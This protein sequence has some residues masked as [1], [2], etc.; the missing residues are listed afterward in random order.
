MSEKKY[1]VSV[2]GEG[3]FKDRGSKFFG[4][5]FHVKDEEEVSERM[6]ETRKRY[7]DARHH[8][9]A[10]RLDKDTLYERANDDGEPG[11]SAGDPILGQIKSA[12][13]IDT[14]VIVV[15]YFG[16]TKLG[17]P[18]LIHAYKTAAAEALANAQ[19]VQV[20]P[21]VRLLLQF[22]YGSLGSVERWMTD[23][24]CEVLERDFQSECKLVFNLREELLNRF[25]ETIRDHYMINLLV[26]EDT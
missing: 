25:K 5:A 14:L 11:H 2:S 16:G 24:E 26:D 23:F 12:N 1:T 17:V 18:G 20:I 19:L 22:G 4:L 3:E 13:L 9:Y 21:Q 7:H 10:F 8:C 15:R 6:A